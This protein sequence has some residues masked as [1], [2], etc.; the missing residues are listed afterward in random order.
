MCFVISIFSI[1]VTIFKAKLANNPL[2]FYY[3]TNYMGSTDL[4]IIFV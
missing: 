3:K 1:F 2:Y 4:F